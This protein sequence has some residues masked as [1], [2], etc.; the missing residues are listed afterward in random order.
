MPEGPEIRRAADA[1]AA[2]VV[3]KRLTLVWFAFDQ[4]KRYEKTLC[5]RRLEAIGARGKAMLIRFDNGLTLYSHNQLY[6]VWRIVQSGEQPQTGRSLRVQLETADKA[7][8]LYSASDISIWPSDEVDQ[9]PFLQRI[10]PDVLDTSL[11]PDAV[12]AR[13]LEPRFARRR[14]GTLLLDQGF[15]AGLGNYLR[16]E[17]L[18]QTQLPA[19]CRPI[20]LDCAGRAALAHALLDVPRRSYRTRGKRGAGHLQDTLFKFNAYHRAGKPCPRCATPIEKSTVAGRPFY[21][22]PQCQTA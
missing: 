6:G 18:W 11:D 1:L 2:A 16:V 9:H 8:L 17:I 15:L 5:G 10:G 13:L 22:C 20:D 21:A 4:L 7:I 12:A 19:A 14:L 3:G